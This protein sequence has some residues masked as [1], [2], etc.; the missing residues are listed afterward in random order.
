MFQ[1]LKKIF[2][3]SKNRALEDLIENSFLVD[4][5]T[6]VEFLSGNVKGSVNIPLDQIP[7]E[8]ASFKDKKSIIVFCASGVRSNKAKSILEK[9]GFKNVTDGGTWKSVNQFTIH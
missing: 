8:L 4:V 6:P 3:T 7:N 5:R 2:T 1:Y 9:N